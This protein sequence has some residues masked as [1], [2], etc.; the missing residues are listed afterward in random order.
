MLTIHQLQMKGGF[1]EMIY[2]L[3]FSRLFL[4]WRVSPGTYVLGKNVH[5][6]SILTLL[7]SGETMLHLIGPKHP[8]TRSR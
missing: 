4:I 8:T 2:V 3:H 7:L 1:R 6:T 5:L